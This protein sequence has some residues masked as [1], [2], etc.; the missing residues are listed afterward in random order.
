MGDPAGRAGLF[1]SGD[2]AGRLAA[3][4][5][6]VESL[7][8]AAHA[9]HLAGVAPSLA[10]L[11]VGGFGRRELFPHS[12]ID[13]LLLV[14]S[15]SLARPAREGL[16]AFQRELWDAGLRLSHSVRTVRECC[17]LH[18]QNVELS[19]SL[20]DERFLAGDPA[21]YDRLRQRLPKFLRAE[22]AGLVRHLCRLARSRHAAQ[23][24]T[25]YHLEPNIKES[26]GG[27]RDIHLLGWLEHL[28]AGSSLAAVWTGDLEPA[29]DFLYTLRCF[30]HDRAR[31][32]NNVLGFDAQEEAAELP[33]FRPPGDTRT[34]PARWMRDYF[35]HVRAVHR[36][37]LRALETHEGAGSSLLAGFR[38]WR[39]R[40][41]NSDFTVARDR[42]YFKAPQQLEGDPDLAL[43]LFLFVARH[44]IRP[45]PDAERRLSDHRP[46]LEAHF[47]RKQPVWDSV[48][49]LLG[50][51][52]AALALRVM[53]ETGFLGLLLPEWEGIECLV[54]RD[55]YHRY[56]VDEHTL[57]AVENLEELAKTTDPPRRRF[58]ALLGEMDN[59]APL[60]LALLLHDAGKGGGDGDHSIRS[61]QLAEEAMERM[62]VPAPAQRLVSLLI[63]HHLDLS[64]AMTGRDLDDPST[65][66]YLAGRLETLEA[67]RYLVLLTY[68]DVS[69]VNPSALSPWRLEQ[70]W[71]VYLITFR[72]LTRELSTD[73]ILPE[74]GESVEIEAFLKGFPTRYQRTHSPPEIA[75]HLE[76]DR[77]RRLSGVALE[78]VRV[79]GGYQLTILAKDRLFLFAS[80]AGALSSFGMNILKAEA[81]AN[82]Q[83]TILD[84][85]VFA[86]PS[87][88]LELNP[89]EKDRLRH[90]LERVAIGRVNVKDLLKH[91]PW[92]A[93]PSARGR[94]EARVTFDVEASEAATLIEVVAEDRP[95][96]LYDLASTLSES[97]CSI[98]VVLV[99]TEAHRALDVFYVTSGGGKLSPTLAESLRDRLF[100]VLNG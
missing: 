25:I 78:I 51:P 55:F 11:A 16:S 1:A 22:R 97:G 74:E 24:D 5:C 40:L 60:Y 81:F 44:G 100:A 53:H 96:L 12:D 27:I 23:H 26:P 76:L 91:R 92:P 49:E 80:I 56:T 6:S 48:R 35:R 75:T 19:I 54:V 38:D 14:D 61:V 45:S 87:R 33:F 68:A 63:E 4:T 64:S 46:T 39:G 99:D 72:E 8:L 83:G 43:R 73:R 58:A 79:D 98:D 42:L 70:L 31:R 17:E 69:A 34:R 62:E 59:P 29:R 7:I 32:D 85:F 67:L 28:R 47:R 13:V 90:T 21:L 84:T 95:G 15:D 30:L 2:A 3:R 88:T 65:A 41:S 77:Q 9:A 52:Q 37:A 89:T 10:V 66:R 36:A 50:L 71:R 18:E 94:V 20:L 82:Q 57:V 93:A 86:D